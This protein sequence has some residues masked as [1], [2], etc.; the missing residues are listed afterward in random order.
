MCFMP[1]NCIQVKTLHGYTIDNLQKIAKE[2]KSEYTRSFVYAVIM[3][4]QGY[5]TLDIMNTL[6]KSRP[7]VTSYINSWNESPENMLDQ[8]GNNLPVQLTDSIINDIKNIITNCKPSEFGYPQSTWTSSLITI[9]IA[10]Q[11]GPK[12]S[13][14]WIRKLLKA[15]GFSYKRGV[16]MPTKADPELQASF[17]KNGHATGHY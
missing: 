10:E 3:R 17:K 12:Y 7:T 16:Y 6:G 1:R 8:R 4:F 11:Y 5:N 15:F 13:S 9:Y 2:S 14:S